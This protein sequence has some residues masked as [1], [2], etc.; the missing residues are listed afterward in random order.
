V[1]QS[2]LVAAS[3]EVRQPFRDLVVE[4]ELS[5]IAQLQDRGGGEL[6]GH[7]ADRDDGVH[8]HR[9]VPLDV[10]LAV[11]LEEQRVLPLD[12]GGHEADGAILANTGAGNGVQPRDVPKRGPSRLRRRYGG[13]AGLRSDRSTNRDEHE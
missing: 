11:G 3:V 6:L 13:Q 7:G 2:D 10:G 9:H 5:L 4:A 8:G 12:D 1:T